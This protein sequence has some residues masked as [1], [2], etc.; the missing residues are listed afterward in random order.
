VTIPLDDVLL[1]F[2]FVLGLQRFL[3]RPISLEEARATLQQRLKSRESDFLALAKS[4][5]YTNAASPY[6]QLLGLA[7]CEYGDLE[8]LARQQGAEGALQALFE[9][10][11]YLT[12]EEFKGRAPAVRGSSAVTGAAG[13]A[14]QPQLSSSPADGEQRKSVQTEHDLAGPGPHLRDIAVRRG[15]GA[16]PDWQ[17]HDASDL[18]GSGRRGALV[19][20]G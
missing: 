5:I 19:P 3:R 8:R 12:V 10:G 13:R 18:A 16:G 7:G 4:A 17:E 2:R 20:A 15:G 9:R 6:R 14:V 11:V 1:G